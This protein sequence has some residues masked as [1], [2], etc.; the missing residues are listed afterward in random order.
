MRHPRDFDKSLASL[1]AEL[2]TRVSPIMVFASAIAAP[3]SIGIIFIILI[4]FTFITN[5]DQLFKAALIGIVLAPIAE[6]SKLITRRRRPETLYVKR[7]RFK[8]YSFPSGHSYISVL[9]FGFLAIL[10][11]SALPYGFIVSL[12]LASLSFTVG[13]S[14]I[15][16][17]AHFPSDVL[18]GWALGCAVLIFWVKVGL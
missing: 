10:A 14:R 8:T 13:V 3:V 1:V 5:N 15:Y 11:T 4:I 16:L 6:L 18:A 12:V 9:V 7:M 17:G 2:P